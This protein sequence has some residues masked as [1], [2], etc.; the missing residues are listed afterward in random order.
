M[1]NWGL[2]N[3]MICNNYGFCEC[4]FIGFACIRSNNNIATVSLH[5]FHSSHLPLFL[6][7]SLAGSFFRSSIYQSHTTSS[8]WQITLAS[9]AG[10]NSAKRTWRLRQRKYN[11][12][13]SLSLLPSND[14]SEA[15]CQDLELKFGRE[16]LLNG[17]KFTGIDGL[18][19]MGQF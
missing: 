15:K 14:W 17:H 6:V 5:L 7:H 1:S 2:N 3:I 4:H 13:L 18:K 16:Y 12:S 8:P 9:A 19:L 10:C 11:F